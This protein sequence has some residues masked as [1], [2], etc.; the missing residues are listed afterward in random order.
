MNKTTEALKLAEQE[1]QEPVVGYAYATIKEYEEL[2]G[3]SVPEAF[4][5]GWNMA[6]TTNSMLGIN[7]A[8][9]QPVKQEP[10]F[11]YRPINEETYE[12]PVHNDSVCGKMWRNEKPGEW[13]PLYAAPVDAKA[14]RAEA[15]E[16]AAKMCDETMKDTFQLHGKDV[17]EKCAAAIRGLK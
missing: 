16:E 1:K 4:R 6:R 9:V 7:T 13:L 11:W 3:F 10:V 12:G 2:A 5:A 15:L 14:I 17:A 8:P